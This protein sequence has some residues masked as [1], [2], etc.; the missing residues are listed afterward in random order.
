LLTA[1]QFSFGIFSIALPVILYVIFTQTYGDA[2][3]PDGINWAAM[4]MVSMA[5]YGSLGAAMGGGA[6]LA[7]ERRSGWFR[8]LNITA[9][10][11]QIFLLAKSAGDHGGGAAG[12]DP[13]LRGRFVVGG[14][15]APATAWLACL[16]LMWL[17][18]LPM[19][20][21]GVAIG[22]WVGADAVPG[23]TTVVLLMLSALGGLWFPVQIMPNVMQPSP[24]RCRRTGWPSWDACR[25]CQA[26]ASRGP[27]SRCCWAGRS[28]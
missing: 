14:V 5:A 2:G 3:G 15:R 1:K 18:L 22:L 10:P 25:S 17:A 27:E 13:G 24:R 4:I 21:L 9:L 28:G 6:Q 23:V 19:T 12:V 16:A 8:Q 7:L 11:S 26:P 20:I